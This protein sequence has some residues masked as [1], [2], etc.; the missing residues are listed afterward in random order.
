MIQIFGYSDDL[1]E[2]EGITNGNCGDAHLELN[3]DRATIILGD[4]TGG[5]CI[6]MRYSDKTMIPGRK[7][8]HGCW[9][10]Q[11][12]QI[13]NGVP[14]PWPIT[15]KHNHKIEYRINDIDRMERIQG[16]VHYS[17]LVEIDAPADTPKTVLTGWRD[18]PLENYYEDKEQ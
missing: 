14:I 5:V 16:R 9:S 10:A 12:V 3:G 8:G 15:I 17:V 2:I 1:I 6:T 4:K 18:Q 11:I 13:D 7:E